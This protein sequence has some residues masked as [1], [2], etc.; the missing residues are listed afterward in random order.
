MQL[1]LS[2]D[3]SAVWLTEEWGSIIDTVTNSLSTAFIPGIY[4]VSYP[5]GNLVSD[6]KGGT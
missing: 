4:S 2:T 6:I 3:W 5:M 1:V